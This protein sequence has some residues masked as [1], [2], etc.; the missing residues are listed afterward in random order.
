MDRMNITDVASKPEADLADMDKRLDFIQGRLI[1]NNE[2]IQLADR[3]AQT[4]LRLVLGLFM[5]AFV[6]VPPTV[7]SLPATVT[8]SPRPPVKVSARVASPSR[9]S[10]C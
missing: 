6:G 9:L 5:I 2:I 10:R 1:A 4:L 8:V 3:K 7:M